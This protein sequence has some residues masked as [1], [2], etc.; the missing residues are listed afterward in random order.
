MLL[1]IQAHY[2]MKNTITPKKYC[3]SFFFVTLTQN[4]CKWAAAPGC[5][6]NH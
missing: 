1:L 6:C 4:I 3:C 5:Q 2:V